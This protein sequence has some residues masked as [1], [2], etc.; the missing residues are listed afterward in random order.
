MRTPDGQAKND[1]MSNAITD[2][3]GAAP[4]AMTLGQ[5]NG[6]VDQ[7]R[8]RAPDALGVKDASTV[9]MT[10][11]RN[12]HVDQHVEV[13][14]TPKR[15]P[16]VQ[17]PKKIGT[18]TAD[19]PDD[20][21]DV[22]AVRHSP[23][24]DDSTRKAN[25][26]RGGAT[27]SRDA[28]TLDDVY[29]PNDSEAEAPH[30]V[31]AFSVKQT[32]PPE[33]SQANWAH[34]RNPV[35]RVTL[36]CGSV[37][38]NAC[39]DSGASNCLLSK[40]AYDRAHAAGF[41]S[42]LMPLRQQ[43]RGA[44]GAEIKMHG[45]CRLNFFLEGNEQRV[46]FMVGE[47]SGVDA[48][49]GLTWLRDMQA[50]I[51]FDGMRMHIRPGQDVRIRTT[52]ELMTTQAVVEPMMNVQGLFERTHG[53]VYVS[54]T[55]TIPYGFAL[56]IE[57]TVLGGSDLEDSDLYFE[58]YWKPREGVLLQDMVSRIG[59]NKEFGVLVSNASHVTQILEQGTLLGCVT[60]YASIVDRTERVYRKTANAEWEELTPDGATTDRIPTGIE[61]YDLFWH[62]VSG[63]TPTR[64]GIP[65][66]S[67]DPATSA[68]DRT[69][70]VDGVQ[71]DTPSPLLSC[72]EGG[73]EVLVGAVGD[74][75]REK[76]S[77]TLGGKPRVAE[78]L[79]DLPEH[80]R[81]MIPGSDVLSPGERARVIQTVYDYQD[82]FTD[83]E[84]NVGCSTAGTHN[85]DTGA[86]NPVNLRL[87]QKSAAERQTISDEVANLLKKGIIRP[88]KSPWGAPVVL[89]K[90]K[91]GTLRFCIDYRQLNQVTK[92]DAYP[93]P[94]IDECLGCLNGTKYYCTLDLASGYWQIAVYPSDCE[95]T[96]FVTH[97]GLFEWIVMPF[98]LCNAPA[99]FCRVMERVLRG[100][101]WLKCLV[102]L[103]D[104]IAF[105]KNFQECL[106]SL[107]DVF[108]R[109]REFNLK[110]K[111]KKCQLFRTKVEYLGH[112][113]SADGIRPCPAGLVTLH[114][115]VMPTD[116]HG[117]RSFL[118]FCSYYRKFI[119]DFSDIAYPLT[120][121]T[122]KG[123]KVDTSTA[124]C[125]KAFEDL[126]ARL[127]SIPRL[128]HVRQGVPFILDT[129]ASDRAIGAC[130][131]QCIVNDKGEMEEIPITYASKTL[132]PSRR[133]Y[134]TTKKELY[135]V[136]FFMRYF[137][138]Y[139]AQTH[140]VIRTDHGSLKWLISFGKG[141]ATHGS[142]MY[143]R[144]SV[145]LTSYKPWEIVHRAGKKH[146]NADYLSRME[147][148]HKQQ[149]CGYDFCPD[150]RVVQRK[151]KE[152]RA[153]ESEDSD[154]DPEE[155]IR[156]DEDVYVS[157]TRAA[158][159]RASYRSDDAPHAN[160][161]KPTESGDAVE[162]RRSARIAAQKLM[163]P[164]ASRKPSPAPKP[165]TGRKRRRRARYRRGKP[166]KNIP[167]ETTGSGANI[168]P[169]VA[170]DTETAPPE[171]IKRH[172]TRD[173]S[174]GA[175]I[176]PTT[177]PIK[178]YDPG[179]SEEPL[180]VLDYLSPQDWADAQAADPVI[181]RLN[182]VKEIYGERRPSTSDLRAEQTVVRALCQQWS[183][184]EK[185]KHGIWYRIMTNSNPTKDWSVIRQRLVPT[186][187]Q[188]ALFSR[189]HKIECM[190]MG[191][192][193]V[194]R[195]LFQRYYW[196][197]MSQDVME[198]LK[199]CKQCQQAKKGPGGA[200]GINKQE[201]SG[202]PLLRLG[203]DLQGPFPETVRGS[204]YILVVQ[205]YNSRWIELF[206]LPDKSAAT[207]A[208]KLEDE[209]F[210][211]YGACVRLH[212]DQGREFDC[213]LL[214]QICL[215][216]GIQKTR[217]TPF[218]P[219]SNGLVER[220]N[221]SIKGILRHACREG[222]WDRQIP[223]IRM[224][225]NSTEHRTTGV[226]PYKM[227]FSRCSEATLPLDLLT[228]NR[229]AGPTS[230]CGLEY[231]QRQTLE[232]QK[233]A[234]IVR[235]HTAKQ[236]RLYVESAARNGLRIRRYKIGDKVWRLNV[237]N[238][239]DKLN[240]TPWLGPYEILDQNEENHLIKLRVPAPGRT[241]GTVDKWI[242][243]SSV[244]PVRTYQGRTL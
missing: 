195:M 190:H 208:Q 200:K 92:K 146:L 25:P 156:R 111:P 185:D 77:T 125:K 82:V 141:N 120:A 94:R 158:A 123:V 57:C 172:A 9:A 182:A 203:V 14:A 140:V 242:H 235:Q 119:P 142:S 56:S 103:D 21:A 52:P 47:L 115:W 22:A 196:W 187:W 75:R 183:Q 164:F 104:I 24:G 159:A 145:E 100:I 133:A 19:L 132:G 85:I 55:Q 39:I 231:V 84:G 150:C 227:F 178:V 10:Y 217:T 20:N 54:K 152:L 126:K 38:I 27:P 149:A 173:G 151:N 244:K 209:V 95:K 63:A 18:H 224:C 34:I 122:K 99:T 30:S 233:I 93:L 175:Q 226:T 220:S 80:L 177:E 81:C 16:S 218:Y 70:P 6:Q 188:I 153:N 96:A 73:E 90:K 17:G 61:R 71:D 62:N 147:H 86:A 105:G 225:L 53:L 117:V 26:E 50:L 232:C 68:S 32:P 213:Q 110:L 64:E 169:P 3:C 112:E 148:G 214:R 76:T 116:L 219:Q 170:V 207:V 4:V 130:L 131:S 72:N 198:W 23:H 205:D 106:A 36:R 69:T 124:E 184:L 113:I 40:K 37:E 108:K 157:V 192:E 89:V 236:I 201:N 193:R 239:A 137:R 166:P 5:D 66:R 165:E 167:R 154:D 102:Y 221:R 67:P 127:L 114:D 45:W 180:V 15:I 33:P 189:V 88:S 48:L 29:T 223:K 194:Y 44:S 11:G 134:C 161:Q 216:W 143:V 121:L 181:A 13:S 238:Q 144:W 191:Y 229:Q 206:A 240:A 136:V 197:N 97:E 215:Y 107:I 7:Q 199:C 138:G 78:R 41:A 129:D 176:K 160:D 168:K 155:S 65:V 186:K 74:D 79:D 128:H 222:E 109:L 42:P 171:P 58:P 49:L 210:Y 204:K 179:K 51:D 212:S 2:E 230:Y 139:T 162:T 46:A 211:R 228:S 163:R 241:Q 87:R 234:E 98:G 43:L 59:H 60:H 202:T 243:K 83:K 31:G 101:V 174:C 28:P 1:R 12:C 135:A 91:D 35:C 118:G 8:E 237:P